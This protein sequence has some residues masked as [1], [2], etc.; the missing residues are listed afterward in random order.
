MCRSGKPLKGVVHCRNGGPS[1]LSEPRSDLQARTVET[2]QWLVAAATL[3]TVLFAVTLHYEVS[4]GL[5]RRLA[6]SPLLGRRR[7]LFLIFG[8]LLA[9]VAEIWLFATT[10][11]LLLD[12]PGAGE[13]VGSETLEFLD[14]VYMSAVTYTTLGYGDVVPRGNIRFLLG[15]EALTGFM[16]ITWSAS[17]TFLEMQQHWRQG[18]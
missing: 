8:L 6:R 14:M 16:L 18:N 17:L 4:V 7:V 15:T 12:E 2:V 11:W 13:L 5:S 10:L 9:H 1:L 3:V